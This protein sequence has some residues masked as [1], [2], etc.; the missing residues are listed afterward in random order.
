MQ[1]LRSTKKGLYHIILMSNCH[2]SFV[3]CPLL[4]TNGQY[5]G[6]PRQ[7]LETLRV[8]GAFALA[9]R[10]AQVAQYK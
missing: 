7:L 9:I 4:L 2:L 8:S 1:T 5:F 6:L 10:S 3:I